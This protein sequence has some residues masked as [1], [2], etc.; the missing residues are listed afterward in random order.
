MSRISDPTHSP[1]R[2]YVLPPQI[3]GVFKINFP[4]V[5]NLVAVGSYKPKQQL[6]LFQEIFLFH[7]L[8]HD[9]FL[10]IN[11]SKIFIKNQKI[12]NRKNF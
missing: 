4:V 2:E 3:P 9:L 8:F 6:L 12:K 10:E 1:F 5:A 11:S 7:N